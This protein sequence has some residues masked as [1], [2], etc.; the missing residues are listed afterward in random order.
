MEKHGPL[1][2]IC[3]HGDPDEEQAFC[4]GAVLCALRVDAYDADALTLALV[5]QH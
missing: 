4:T 3:Y 2:P 1:Q 5:L